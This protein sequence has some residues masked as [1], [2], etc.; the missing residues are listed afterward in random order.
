MSFSIIPVNEALFP[1]PKEETILNSIA[2]NI[3]LE[4]HTN[5]DEFSRRLL[6]RKSKA[7][8]GVVKPQ[9]NQNLALKDLYSIQALLSSVTIR[10]TFDLD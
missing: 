4:H 2:Q 10:K 9:C 8:P 1:S 6:F 5:I 7:E 3:E